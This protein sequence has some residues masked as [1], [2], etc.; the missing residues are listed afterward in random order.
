MGQCPAAAYVSGAASQQ[1]WSAY[2][3][4]DPGVEIGD[5]GGGGGVAQ[6]LQLQPN[7]PLRVVDQHQHVQAP[8]VIPQQVAG[9][10]CIH[11]PHSLQAM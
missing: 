3:E 10:I 11:P 1:Q 5:G 9:P 2:N 7:H 8:P 4:D 6:S